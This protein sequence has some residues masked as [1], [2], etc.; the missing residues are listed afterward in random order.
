MEEYVGF[1]EGEAIGVSRIG[2]GKGEGGVGIGDDE[3]ART[4]CLRGHR[5]GSKQKNRTYCSYRWD[6]ELLFYG[7]ERLCSMLS[8]SHDHSL[9][10]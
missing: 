8:R 5:W 1:G 4:D 10:L 6:N 7:E 2:R 9:A 3:E